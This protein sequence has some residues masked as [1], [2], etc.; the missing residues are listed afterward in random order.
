[1]AGAWAWPSALACGGGVAPP[2][3]RRETGIS[4]D[5]QDPC[6]IA[7]LGDTLADRIEEGRRDIT[8]DHGEASEAGVGGAMAMAAAG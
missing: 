6:E 1:V 5:G 7:N 2:G 8:G 3:Q 4:P